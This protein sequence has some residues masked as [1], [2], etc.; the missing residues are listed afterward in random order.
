MDIGSE[1]IGLANLIAPVLKPLFLLGGAAWECQIDFLQSN[2]RDVRLTSLA[3]SKT[4]LGRRT[5]S[6]PLAPIQSSSEFRR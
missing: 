3:C 1:A 2:I 5:S 4:P 6:A